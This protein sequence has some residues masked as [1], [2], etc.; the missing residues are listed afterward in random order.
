ML[1]CSDIA[2]QASDYLDGHLSV[3]QRLAF[4]VHLLLC[5]KCKEFLRQLGLALRFYQQLPPRQLS[6]EAAESLVST[7][8]DKHNPH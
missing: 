7:I 1:S 5:G 6:K 4:A 2:K 3:R 8:L